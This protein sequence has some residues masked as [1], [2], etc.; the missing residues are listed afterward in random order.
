MIAPE[1]NKTILVLTG[2]IQRADIPRICEGVRTWLEN[3][4]EEIVICD[5]SAV[6]P[7]AVT[8]EAFARLELMARRLGKRILFQ[9]P[10]GELEEL[11]DL[12]GLAGCIRSVPELPLET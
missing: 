12:T 4:H 6:W 1:T 11:L 3:G 8:I 9:H 10:T 2:Q 7:D 5:V